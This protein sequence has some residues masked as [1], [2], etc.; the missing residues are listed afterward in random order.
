MET[1][2]SYQ[3][4]ISSMQNYQTTQ[5][6]KNYQEPFANKFEEIY[7]QAQDADINLKNAKD[8]LQN[9]SSA[10]LHTLQKYSGLAQAIDVDVISAEGAYNLL[11]HDNEQY[12]FNNDGIAEVGISKHM[13]PIPTTMPV[14]VRDAYIKAMNSLDDKDKLMSMMLTFDMGHLQSQLEG[15]PYKPKTVDYDYLSSRVDSILNPKPPA[16]TSEKTKESI[17]AFWEAFEASYTGDKT[18]TQETQE[19]SAVAKFLNDLTTKGAA[20]FLADF[21]MEKIQAKIDEFR[22]KLEEQMGDSPQAVQEIEKMIEDYTKQLLEE[23]Q[24]SLDSGKEEKP[25]TADAIIKSILKMKVD[26]PAK[27][28]EELLSS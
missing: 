7:N 9:L 15:T 26:N 28:L 13:L 1:S 4:Y 5:G 19:D 18:K 24:E 21:N 8:F 2:A 22:K 27:P 20:K 3:S 23:L 6:R 11:M 16:F 14:D 12:D 25:G 10:E 17:R